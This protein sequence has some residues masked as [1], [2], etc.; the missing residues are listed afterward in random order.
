MSLDKVN[1][2]LQ[3]KKAVPAP[4]PRAGMARERKKTRDGSPHA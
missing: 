3:K 2:P 4:I 1:I